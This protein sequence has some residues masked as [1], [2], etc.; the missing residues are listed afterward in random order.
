MGTFRVSGVCCMV[1]NM[2]T[3]M[4]GSPTTEVIKHSCLV[5]VN[6]IVIGRKDSGGS[7]GCSSMKKTLAEPHVC[8]FKLHL[9]MSMGLVPGTSLIIPK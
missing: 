3:A 8:C 1:C 6:F 9:R 7:A 4:S 2:K 5:N